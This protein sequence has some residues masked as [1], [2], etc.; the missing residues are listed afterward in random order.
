[1]TS[2]PEPE[3][4]LRPLGAFLLALVQLSAFM[5]VW[6]VATMLAEVRGEE[7]EGLVVGRWNIAAAMVLGPLTA[8][9]VG[10]NRYAPSSAT[11]AALGLG[12]PGGRQVVCALVAA[13]GGALLAALSRPSVTEPV[14]VLLLVVAYPLGSELLYRGFLQPRLIRSVGV[15]RALAVTFTLFVVGQLHP[16]LM[17]GAAVVGALTG[18]AAWRSGSTWVPLAAH[19]GHQGSLFLVGDRLPPA[20]ALGAVAAAALVVVIGRPAR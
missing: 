18:V 14:S 19:L 1:V 5:T 9:F 4:E 15:W 16:S 6:L 13:L 10:L 7:S 2:P 8:L 11:A 12:R 17:P 20:A 3:A